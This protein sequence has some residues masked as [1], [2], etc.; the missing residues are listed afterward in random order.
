MDAKTMK[1]KMPSGAQ[2]RR[3]LLGTRAI[4]GRNRSP[5]ERPLSRPRV[6]RQLRPLEMA[7]VRPQASGYY[8]SWYT[9][10]NLA[11]ED[12]QSYAAVGAMYFF[13]FGAGFQLKA[14]YGFV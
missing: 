1:K 6:R 9:K 8:E 14:T 7:Q 2:T 11:C 13:G 10:H 5:T 3:R 4:R 12:P